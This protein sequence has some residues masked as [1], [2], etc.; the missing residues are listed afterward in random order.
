MADEQ[1]LDHEDLTDLFARPGNEKLRQT[2]HAEFERVLKKDMAAQLASQ[3]EAIPGVVEHG[4]FSNV[5]E[6]YIGKKDGTVEILK[7]K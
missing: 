1:I 4:I 3:I 7:K 2:I 6:V 5:D